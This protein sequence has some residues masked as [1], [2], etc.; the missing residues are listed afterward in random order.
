MVGAKIAVA[1][2]DE[3]NQRTRRQRTVG[4]EDEFRTHADAFRM[5]GGKG[6]MTEISLGPAI[7]SE[8]GE[9]VAKKQRRGGCS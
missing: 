9:S 8:D 5:V 4:E 6:S 2:W 7:D 1:K 3:R